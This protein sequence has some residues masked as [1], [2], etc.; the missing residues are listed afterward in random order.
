MPIGTP[1]TVDPVDHYTEWCSI[2]WPTANSEDGSQARGTPLMNPI[3]VIEDIR[4]K[5]GIGHPT[6]IDPAWKTTI[7]NFREQLGNSLVL[8]S[9]QLYQDEAHYFLELLQNADDAHDGEY[10]PDHIPTVTLTVEPSRLVFSNNEHGF[11]A[12]EVRALCGVGKS[13]KKVRKA[14][15]IGE[16][17]V[18]FK[19]VFQVSDRPEVHSNGFH[20]RFDRLVNGDLGLVIPEWCSEVADV[21]VQPG[22]TVILPARDGAKPNFDFG[23]LHPELLLFLRRLRRLVVHDQVTGLSVELRRDDRGQIVEVSRIIRQRG[24]EP[25]TETSRFFVH[26]RTVSMDQIT[27][28][29]RPNI[30]ETEVVI[31]LPVDADGMAHESERRWVFAFLPVT[32]AGL[33]FVCHADF[34]LMTNRGGVIE[35]RPWND[36][37][38]DEL[39]VTFTDAIL[40]AQSLPTLG[41]TALRFLA[42]PEN[43][44]SPFYKP[45]LASAIQ[46]LK[47]IACV[48]LEGDGWDTPAKTLMRD[49]GGLSELV[50]AETL[51]RLIARKYIDTSG[52]RMST[53][54]A[55]LGCE[56]FGIG[57]LVTCLKDKAWTA[58]C[59]AEWFGKLYTLLS[60]RTLSQSESTGLR[61]GYIL[62]LADGAVTLGVT[63]S[64]FRSLGRRTSYGFEEEL[65]LLDPEVLQSVDKGAADSVR[66]LLITWGI[67]DADPVTLIDNHILPIHGGAE[68]SKRNPATLIGHARYVRDHLNDYLKV[69]GD[70]VAQAAALAKLGSTLYIQTGQ[71]AKDKTHF[72]RPDVLY[73]ANGFADP[74]RLRDLLGESID[75]HTVSEAYVKR[76]DRE[77]AERDRDQWRQFFTR[78]GSHTLP[79]VIPVDG[80][81]T[82][83]PEL[84]A[85]IQS[86][87][88]D[89]K[90]RLVTLLD[91]NWGVYTRFLQRA[92][93]GRRVTA[94]SDSSFVQQL[95]G[96]HV[97][98]EFGTKSVLSKC[99]L[100]TEENVAVFGRGMPYLTGKWV[101]EGFLQAV[102]VVLKPSVAQV[103]QRLDAIG[104][105]DQ[106]SS[107]QVKQEVSRLYKFLESRFESHQADIQNAFQQKQIVYIASSGDGT[108][109]T[110][111]ECCWSLPR[112]LDDYAPA[113]GLQASWPELEEFFCTRLGLRKN[114]TGDEWVATLEALAGDDALEVTRAS[115]LALRIYRGMEACCREAIQA[116]ETKGFDWAS[117]L[118]S[119]ELIWTRKG[120]WWHNDDDV[121]IG[122]DR[123]L[124]DVFSNADGVAFLDIPKDD[125]PS[126]RSV[127]ELLGVSR[128]SDAVEVT[129][130]SAR[131]GQEEVK[132]ADRVMSRWRYFIRYLWHKHPDSYWECIEDGRLNGLRAAHAY[133]YR[134]LE[135][136][137]EL[138]GH[139]IGRRFAVRCD[140]DGSGVWV[141][142]D[143]DHVGDWDGIG[144]ELCRVLGLPDT[145]GLNLGRILSAKTSEECEQFL[146]RLKIAD[147][148]DDERLRWGEVVKT[149]DET[150][151]AGE[152]KSEHQSDS[153]T[154]ADTNEPVRDGVLAQVGVSAERTP[155][156]EAGLPRDAD[157]SASIKP[158]AGSP[159]V[160][161]GEHVETGAESGGLAQ[162]PIGTGIGPQGSAATDGGFRQ[163]PGPS[164]GS[165]RVVPNGTDDSA[166]GGASRTTSQQ[167]QMASSEHRKPSSGPHRHEATEDDCL[168]TS[169]TNPQGDSSVDKQQS[170]GSRPGMVDFSGR[171]RGSRNPAPD[172]SSWQRSPYES[173]ANWFRARVGPERDEDAEAQEP[174]ACKQHSDHAPRALVVGFEEAR[175]W[176]AVPASDGQRGY[177]VLS[178]NPKTG[179]R[180]FIEV[181]GVGATW[182][183]DA[184]V[185]LTRAQFDDGRGFEGANEDYWLY[186]V[187]RL[188][189]DRPR[190]IAIRNPSQQVAWFYFQAQD[191]IRE[192][193]D[194]A[195]VDAP[196]AE[197]LTEATPTKAPAL[198]THEAPDPAR[199]DGD[200]LAVT[201][202]LLHPLLAGL[203]NLPLPA[204]QYSVFLEDSELG[205]AELAWPSSRVAVLIPQQRQS[206]AA[207][208]DA[209]W[210]TKVFAAEVDTQA[211]LGW[212]KSVLSA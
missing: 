94:P 6:T 60:R 46:R 168:N 179:E 166:Q 170:D 130:P 124:E 77:T 91:L 139:E 123:T 125:L 76:D 174:R 195:E 82:P 210:S 48:P 59:P 63:P 211:T 47:Q 161:E 138:H 23:R 163:G 20:F 54:L 157:Q 87:D 114:L 126:V 71:K 149:E 113:H 140:L 108:W 171:N 96:M 79:R 56:T 55:L 152:E 43:I 129:P 121:F 109:A 69:K 175:G 132:L 184:T 45:V 65:K 141:Y 183:D 22:T 100:K 41:R 12:D 143:A 197:R 21:H 31:A 51:S 159:S 90:A 173:A 209:G 107:K 192:A 188:S 74:W 14:D 99:Y 24:K 78:L 58:T 187:D 50:D 102:Q 178:R 182:D 37:L 106:A 150:A 1:V 4:R 86:E 111:E 164:F 64:V 160:P 112:D 38:R 199:I 127:I 10:P 185:R 75:Q 205:L 151:P 15:Q 26:R 42:R 93:T 40:A 204:V 118:R 133:S 137:V 156:A 142:V 153:E 191:W 202:P 177:D 104:Y 212:L 134:P 3:D 89:R 27:E 117:R 116:G 95:R 110:L 165:G 105:D 186:V 30:R 119:G 101:S 53:A 83:S 85:L 208:R 203:G 198:A 18:G 155:S 135:M 68:W 180:R 19:A 35:G 11:V 8:L 32:F 62:R 2:R 84:A 169:G 131:G 189:S 147:L 7:E 39:A 52:P 194:I 190:V 81:W 103:I 201:D 196:P 17:G 148:P 162:T 88:W 44:A 49:E 144:I 122:D 120:Q 34:V 73:V 115:K 70:A 167:T 207:L 66:K 136:N 25:T 29:L 28:K 146:S 158:M 13:T 181:K 176:E 200:I 80:D 16:K 5:Y 206:E 61:N 98:T 72:S 128:L 92:S 36:R 154:V 9:D 33:P 97:Q 67:R 193:E 172:S 57:T 145:D